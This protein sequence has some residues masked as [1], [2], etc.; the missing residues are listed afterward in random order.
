MRVEISKDGLYDHCCFCSA[1]LIGRKSVDRITDAY[2]D[3][4]EDVL[5]DYVVGGGERETGF[6]CTTEFPEET[7]VPLMGRSGDYVLIMVEQCYD[8]HDVE[9]GDFVDE[10]VYEICEDPIYMIAQRW[11]D[12]MNFGCL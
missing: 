8:E 6:S 9:N 10:D 4:D 1:V 2:I 3:G 5:Y 12:S 7:D 11:G